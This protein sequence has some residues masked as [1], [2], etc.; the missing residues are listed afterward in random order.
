MHA[1]AETLSARRRD[2]FATIHE[3]PPEHQT[4]HG[5][6]TEWADWL[7][8]RRWSADQSPMFRLFRSAE[9][10]REYGAP[11]AAPSPVASRALAVEGVV[12]ELPDLYRELLRGW[13]VANATPWRLAREVGV[14]KD[15]LQHRLYAA[16]AHADAHLRHLRRPR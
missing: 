10:R 11:T 16:R 13:Y 1:A 12:R 7:R 2:P 6:L 3:I 9:H 4:V 5:E 15:E 14:R 8:L